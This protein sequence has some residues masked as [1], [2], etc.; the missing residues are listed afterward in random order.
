[1]PG[2]PPTA[3]APMS[4]QWS[5]LSSAQEPSLA[6][7]RCTCEDAAGG[8]PWRVRSTYC[9]RLE[10]QGLELNLAQAHPK[11][12]SLTSRPR[13]FSGRH[14]EVLKQREQLT[15]LAHQDITTVSWNPKVG[16]RVP[17]EEGWAGEMDEA[18]YILAER[19]VGREGRGSG[20][21]PG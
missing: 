13:G 6:P 5:H 11:P 19:M 8:R 10:S 1:M 12:R 21:A 16:E 20:R 14:C 15:P 4:P 17:A 2:R 18:G 3:V 9:V 7:A